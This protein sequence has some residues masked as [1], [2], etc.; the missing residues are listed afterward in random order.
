MSAF[1]N[2]WEKKAWPWKYKAVLRIREIAGGIPSNPNVAEGWLKTKLPGY[3]S[4]AALAE[5]VAETMAERG[6]NQESALAVVD[7][8]KHLNGF[9][10]EDGTGYLYIEGRQMKAALKEGAS[11][12]AAAGKIP[13]RGWANNPRKGVISFAAEHIQVD[14]DHLPLRRWPD[15]EAVTRADDVNQRFVATHRGTGIQYEEIVRDAMI[16]ATVRCDMDLGEE[17]W[18]MIWL[19]ACQQGLG[20]SRSQGYGKYSVE[21]WTKLK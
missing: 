11:V 14:D 10:R 2:K 8:L 1:E 20:A 4:E 5:M 7:S 15:G 6:L 13:S 9:K 19:T 17:T 16:T 18:A 12:A 21:E 3:S